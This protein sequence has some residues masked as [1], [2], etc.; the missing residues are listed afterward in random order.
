M[1]HQPAVRKVEVA[2]HGRA[3]ILMDKGWQAADLHV[4]TLFSHDVIPTRSVDPLAL[5]LKARRL[6]LSYISFT[7]HD[8][9]AAYDQIGWTREGLVPGVEVRV[10]D[11]ENVGH[12][13]HFNIYGLD[14]AQYREIRKIAGKARTS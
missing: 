11:P 7:D 3:R 14:R 6:G 9:M 1:S 2:D 10:L 4:H 13:V 12:T 5:Y 8:T